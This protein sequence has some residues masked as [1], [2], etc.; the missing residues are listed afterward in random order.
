V[1]NVNGV[2]IHGE[3]KSAAITGDVTT[4][5]RILNEHKK[6]LSMRESRVLGEILFEQL[7]DAIDNGI[8]TNRMNREEELADKASYKNKFHHMIRYIDGISRKSHL[9][10]SYIPTWDENSL[11]ISDDGTMMSLA[12]GQF[13]HHKKLT[14]RDISDIL[15][16]IT[17]EYEVDTTRL[18]LFN[19][20]R[21]WMD[22]LTEQQKKVAYSFYEVLKNSNSIDIFNETPILMEINLYNIQQHLK[23]Q[24]N[25]NL[26][27]NPWIPH[28]FY[29][30]PV[31]AIEEYSTTFLGKQLLDDLFSTVPGFLIDINQMARHLFRTTGR[32]AKRAEIEVPF[33]MIKSALLSADSLDTVLSTNKYFINYSKHGTKEFGYYWYT[34]YQDLVR[35]TTYN[36]ME[37]FVKLF[38]VIKT[39]DWGKV[40]DKIKE[41]K[42]QTTCSAFE[43]LTPYKDDFATYITYVILGIHQIRPKAF[44]RSSATVN[45]TKI[46]DLMI[47]EICDTLERE[48][49]VTLENG[50]SHTDTIFNIFKMDGYRNWASRFE[51]VWEPAIRAVYRKCESN[52]TAENKMEKEIEHQKETIHRIMSAYSLPSIYRAYS[53]QGNDIITINFNDATK[54][55]AGLHTIPVASGGTVETGII[56]GLAEDNTG[57]WKYL[58]LNTLFDSPSDYWRSLGDH[59]VRMLEDHS[60]TLSKKD[61]RDIQRFITLCDAIDTEGVSYKFKK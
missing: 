4:V 17:D 27:P 37:D 13:L 38:K 59:N 36:D 57:D 32:G 54:T 9:Q 53:H 55:M 60:D 51:H 14:G 15:D 56:W 29:K 18:E 12:F 40:W 2:T 30:A 46:A 10:L 47:N 16:D 3:L 48:I 33:Y 7:K 35:S 49:T 39:R 6:S 1:T 19:N 23:D 21:T 52:V 31:K 22:N 26:Q 41:I 50:S 25:A 11:F 45:V 20:L 34:A 28:N 44:S 5:M 42:D 58:N 43:D 8:I 24:Q 61:I